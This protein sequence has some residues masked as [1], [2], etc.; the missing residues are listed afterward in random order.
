LAA[1]EDNWV[2]EDD[3][4][5]LFERGEGRRLLPIARGTLRMSQSALALGEQVMALEELNSLEIYRK[6]I[7]LLANREGRR[8]QLNAQGPFNALKYRDMYHIL[9]EKGRQ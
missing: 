6:N 4:L 7:L 1:G 5:A 8:F 3:N 9:M 2:L